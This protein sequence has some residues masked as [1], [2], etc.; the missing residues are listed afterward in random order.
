MAELAGAQRGR[1]EM[2]ADLTVGRRGT[3]WWLGRLAIDEHELA[4]RSLADRW[5]P[6][7]S[8]P[9]DAVGD[10]VVTS[11]T[12]VALLLLHWRRVEVVRFAADGPFG[13]VSLRFPR[14][15][16]IADVLRAHGY[17]VRSG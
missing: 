10:I 4:I 14:R 13:D 12:D 16:R 9:R 8:A 5:I 2:R 3:N 15:R 11:R 7:R 6:A 17:S 1:I